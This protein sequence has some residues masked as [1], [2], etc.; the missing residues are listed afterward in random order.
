MYIP[1]SARHNRP[2]AMSV[3]LIGYRGSGKTTVGRALAGRLGWP[4]VDADAVVTERAGMTIRQMFDQL[5]EAGFRAA[6]RAVVAELLDRHDH[7][8]ALGG[9]AVLAEPTRAA[10]AAAGH[11]VVYLRGTPAEL[12]RRIA[13]D[14]LT[15]DARPSLT[16]LGGGLDEV[17]AVL[18]ARE[19][20]YRSAMTHEVDVVGRT[21]DELAEAIVAR[22]ARP[23]VLSEPR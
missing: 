21:V 4:F 12:H 2:P 5:G 23:A 18:A 3:V 19:P 13:A 22:L 16:P 1:P 7:V 11:A 20:I 6:E 17:A 15:A 10:M 14:P 8:L 9:G